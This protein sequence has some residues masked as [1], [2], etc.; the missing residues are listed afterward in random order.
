MIIVTL[1]GYKDARINEDA[2]G[3]I[4]NTYMYVNKPLHSIIIY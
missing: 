4:N 1:E 2:P 3:D